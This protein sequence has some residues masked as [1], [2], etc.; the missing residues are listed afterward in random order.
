MTPMHCGYLYLNIDIGILRK[1]VKKNE[2][3]TKIL[4]SNKISLLLSVRE[5]NL[6][7]TPIGLNLSS[8][9]GM[10]RGVVNCHVF[11]VDREKYW[12]T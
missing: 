3:S 9:D 12:K 1:N 8:Q 7:Y 5:P 4:A 11:C 10:R 2:V 6:T